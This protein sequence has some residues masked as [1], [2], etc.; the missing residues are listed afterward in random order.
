MRLFSACLVGSVVAVLLLV[1]LKPLALR[2]R[3][4]DA[5]GGRK[6]HLRPVPLIGGIAMFGGLIC[7]GVT[8]PAAEPQLGAL[9][10]AAALVVIIGLWD[11]Y[12]GLSTRTRLA[13]QIGKAV[14]LPEGQRPWRGT[15]NFKYVWLVL[16]HF[17]SV[18]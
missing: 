11:D 13:V 10:A 5:P 3:L 9:L 1:W 4:L 7:A 15:Q 6:D 16:G 12:C 14:P 17:S 2:F 8:L 18:G